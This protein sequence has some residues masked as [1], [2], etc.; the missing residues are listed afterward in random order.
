MK[1]F[2]IDPIILASSINPIFAFALTEKEIVE[3]SVGL[4][5]RRNWNLINYQE[6]SLMKVK[7][8]IESKSNNNQC[9]C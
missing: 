7:Q 9:Y 1:R 6:L 4:T 2:P 5:K 8:H 3:F